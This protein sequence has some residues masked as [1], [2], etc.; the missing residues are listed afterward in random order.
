[1]FLKVWGISSLWNNFEFSVIAEGEVLLLNTSY[2]TSL[3]CLSVAI[4]KGYGECQTIP[5]S[6]W[7]VTK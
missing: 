1:M 6:T 3:V 5:L 2:L 4:S 7:A